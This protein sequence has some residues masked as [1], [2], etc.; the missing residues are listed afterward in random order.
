MIHR[1]PAVVVL[2]LFRMYLQCLVGPLVAWT[3]RR[4]DTI[5]PVGDDLEGGVGPGDRSIKAAEAVCP[6][7][8]SSMDPA[9]R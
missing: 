3:R 9:C 6:R 7:L 4:N 5:G 2:P 1:I 8:D